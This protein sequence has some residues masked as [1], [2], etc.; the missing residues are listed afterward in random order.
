MSFS[1]MAPNFAVFS[2]ASAAA[3]DIFATL[4]NR[5]FIE[6]GECAGSKLREIVG[7]IDIQNLSFAYPTRPGA[8]VLKGISLNFPAGKTT[9]LVGS[10]GSGKSTIVGLI[11]RWYDPSEGAVLLDGHDVRDLDLSWMRQ[12]IGIVQQV[13]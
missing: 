12:Q 4:D 5:S 9:A 13:A 6:S 11:E 8:P 1:Q 3:D 10:S 7:T 2:K